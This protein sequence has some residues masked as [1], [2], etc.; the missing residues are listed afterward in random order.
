M[1]ANDRPREARRILLVEDDPD[2]YATARELLAE[3]P[4]HSFEID[5]ANSYGAGLAAIQRGSYDVCLLDWFLG[6]GHGIELV[7]EAGRVGHAPPIILL[8]GNR[9]LSFE[10]E[11]LSAGAADYLVKDELQVAMLERSIRHSI[12]RG[13]AYRMLRDREYELRALFTHA[14]DA[15]VVV[16]DEGTC[17]DGNP[18][19]LTLVELELAE[20]RSRHID[21]LTGSTQD[22]APGPGWFRSDGPR[23]GELTLLRSDGTVRYLE[24]KATHDIMPGRHLAVLRDVSERRRADESR[25]RLAAILDCTD[26]A[27]WG[28]SLAGI[29]DYWSPSSERLYGYAAAEVIGRSATILFP[30]DRTAELDLLLERAR[31]GEAVR[32]FETVR[33]RKD[34]ST[35]EAAATVSPVRIRGEI[36]GTSS[37]TRDVSARNRLQRSLAIAD[38]MTS[39]GTLAAS[40]AH[41]INNP[42][43]VVLANVDVALLS[44]KR[45]LAAPPRSDDL[46]PGAT[47]KPVVTQLQEPL[48]D[49]RIAAVQIRDI[50]RDL[51][52]FSRVDERECGP[53]DLHKVAESALRMAWN[54][55]RH[56]A[57]LVKDYGP[58]P[59]V[60][61]NASRIGQVVVNLVINAAHA[62]PEGD[63]AN[64][65]VCVRLHAQHGGVLLEVRDTGGGIAAAVRER[66][67]EPFFTTKPLGSGT[68]LGLAVC[69]RIVEEAGGRI[70][71]ESEVG[72]GSSFQ[73]WLP[74][75]TAVASIQAESSAARP[76][77]RARVLVVDDE[78]LVGAAI[79]RS[80]CDHHDVTVVTSA[81][82]ALAL[83]ARGE[84]YDVV[85]CDVMMPQLT[86]E[87]LY[88]RMR[89][90]AP[91]HL[92]RLVFLTGGAFTASGRAFLDRGDITHM[93]KPFNKAQLLAAVAVRTV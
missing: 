59:L 35:I 8:T 11:A 14:L 47:L 60:H 38:R 61:G 1:I 91:E 30:P 15:I 55:I 34:G 87:E 63:A 43:S 9:N 31:R 40:V 76:G 74:A 20:L 84:A 85:F 92:E 18:A 77:Q 65:E 21:E 51:K 10:Q 68:G 36:I 28:M 37:I 83:F 33:L 24:F 75:S 88:E 73:V 57:R 29:I 79:R 17:V 4:T 7:R 66:I 48:I 39:V 80:I 93:E 19:L 78:P 58:I 86:G 22:G 64:N 49:C 90:S 53:V 72:K 16:D 23:E 56:R 3:I 13:R 45:L 82:D 5:W 6:D 69:Q 62:I 52:L 46:E 2:D 89:S 70:T 41:E 71:V 50:V 54:E 26:D 44:M 12:D 67:F 25:T 42:L 81:F 32:N 27:V